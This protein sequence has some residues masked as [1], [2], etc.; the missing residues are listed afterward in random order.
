MHVPAELY[1]RFIRSMPIACVDIIVR[2][3]AGMVLLVRRTNKPAQGQWWWPGGRVH[4][5]ET[6][7]TAARRKLAEECSLVATSLRERGT[8][9][10]M[11]DDGA[12][13]SIS[14]LFDAMVEPGPVRLDAQSSEADWRPAGVWLRETLHP[15]VRRMMAEPSAAEAR[16]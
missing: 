6:R 8:F 9:D 14:T 4:F 1:E 7:E 3:P 16:R 11:L 15:F 2:D 13:H 10:L 5:G 12:V